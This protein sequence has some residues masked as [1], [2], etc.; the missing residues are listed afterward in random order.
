MTQTGTPLADIPLPDADRLLEAATAAAD[1]AAC[2]IRPFFRSGVTVDDKSDQSPVTVADRTAERTIRAILAERLPDHA[3]LGEEF[4]LER[5]GSRHCWVIDPID[6]TRAFVTG[7]PTFGTLIALLEDGVPVL[8]IIDQPITGERWIGV[9]G[10]PTHYESRLPGTIGTRRCTELKLAELS[11]TSPEMIADAPTPHWDALRRAARRV[12]WG[13]DCYA[14]GLLALGQVDVIAECTMKIWDW[15]ALVPI[16][17]GA[18]G[19]VTDWHGRTLHAQSDGTV[20]AVGDPAM[21]AD[22]VSLLNTGLPAR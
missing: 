18:G 3:V 4:G 20:L 14:Y 6:G 1:A 9:R 16:I 22:A 11:C 5:V 7:R 2:V 19:R 21:L 17:E 8:G 15:A 12:T 10:R 13:G